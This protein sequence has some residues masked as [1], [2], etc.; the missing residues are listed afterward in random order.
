MPLQR[1]DKL[2]EI[3]PMFGMPWCRRLSPLCGMRS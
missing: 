3:A 2:S 1:L